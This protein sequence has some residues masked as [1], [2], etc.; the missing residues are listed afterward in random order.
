MCL[1]DTTVSESLVGDDTTVCL[2]DT[3][4]SYS[5]VRDDTTVCPDDATVLVLQNSETSF[6]R[7]F[8]YF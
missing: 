1:D 6:F 8:V 7:I 2:Y 3:T 4:V 5:P